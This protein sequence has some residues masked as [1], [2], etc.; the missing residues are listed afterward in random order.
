MD[1]AMS[2]TN[3][4][5]HSVLKIDQLRF[6]LRIQHFVYNDVPQLSFLALRQPRLPIRAVRNR[7]GE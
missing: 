5:I 6:E 3:P 4:L 2:S 7:L 1:V